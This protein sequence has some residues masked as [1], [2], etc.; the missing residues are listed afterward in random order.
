[1]KIT[2]WYV[3]FLVLVLSQCQSDNNHT[4]KNRIDLMEVMP[5]TWES[6]SVNV[7][8]NSVNN[9]D[10]AYVFS[11]EEADWKRKL[12]VQP[13]RHY[14]AADRNYRRESRSIKDTLIDLTRGKWFINGDSIRL[15]TPEATYEYEVTIDNGISTFRSL[16]DWDNDGAQDDEYIGVQRKISRYTE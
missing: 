10:S 3:A 11:I 15:V 5:G 4:D 9:T 7:T 2:V 12:G 8:V 13:L 14:Y 1:M 16:L 6:I